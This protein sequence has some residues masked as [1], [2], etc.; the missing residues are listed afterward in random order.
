MRGSYGDGIAGVDAHRIEVLDGTHDDGVVG[1]IAHHFQLKFFPAEDALFDQYFVNRRKIEATLQNFGQ[2][3]AVVSDPAAR[4]AQ[5]E[6]GA[7]NHR[8]AD[9]IGESQ[10]VIHVVHQLRLRRIQADLAHRIF[11]QQTI[12]GFIDGFD[13]GADQLDAIFVEHSRLA[14]ST[15]RLRPV[16]PP[17]VESRASGRSRRITSSANATVSGST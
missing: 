12:F 7:Q 6:A 8:I 17:T 16:W 9:A 11:E 14:R 1:Q 13:L 4:S 15:D 5:R 3:F 2:V 10:P